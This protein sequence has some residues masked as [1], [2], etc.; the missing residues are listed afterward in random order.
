[1]IKIQTKRNITRKKGI[2]IFKSIQNRVEGKDL[3]RVNLMGSGILL[4][5]KENL[6]SQ[7]KK[8]SDIK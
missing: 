3:C 5:S 7:M 4:I 6:F 8:N 1:M 2:N